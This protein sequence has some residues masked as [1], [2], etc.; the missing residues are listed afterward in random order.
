[1]NSAHSEIVAA[2]VALLKDAV[3]AEGRVYEK[4][5]R[6]ISGEQ[7]SGV[8]VRPT[9]SASHLSSVWGGPTSWSTLVEIESY[10]RNVG[11]VPDALA[12]ATLAAVFECLAANPTVNDLVQDI[13][14]LEGDTLSWDF[15]EL[16]TNLACITAKFVVEHQ[17]IG[18]TLNK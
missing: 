12:D 5:T 10:G 6:A 13:A 7:P 2:I 16:D 4:R 1:M 9:R 14:P 8:V 3:I 17:T 11:G 15:D 18:R